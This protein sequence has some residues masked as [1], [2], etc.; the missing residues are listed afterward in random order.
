[1]K[2]SERETSGNVLRK[3]KLKLPIPV[4]AGET[5]CVDETGEFHNSEVLYPKYFVGT[6]HVN[7]ALQSTEQHAVK[8]GTIRAKLPCDGLNGALKLSNGNY[9]IFSLRIASSTPTFQLLA[10]VSS[11]ETGNTLGFGVSPSTNMHNNSDSTNAYRL[12]HAV[13]LNATNVRVLVAFQLNASNY[14]LKVFNVEIN[15]TTSA[16]TVTALATLPTTYTAWPGLTGYAGVVA[17]ISVS[18]QNFQSYVNMSTN[19]L[20]AMAN[21][22]SLMPTV[23]N[24]ATLDGTKLVSRYGSSTS[25]QVIDTASN[26]HISVVAS[27]ENIESIFQLGP[28]VYLLTTSANKMLVVTFNAGMNAIT[29]TQTF[30]LNTRLLAALGATSGSLN[31]QRALRVGQSKVYIW[32]THGLLLELALD[33]NF[34]ITSILSKADGPDKIYNLGLWAFNYATG[35]SLFSY[36]PDLETDVCLYM[37]N[38]PINPGTSPDYRSYSC[39]ALLEFK[40]WPYVG[41]YKP[42]C[43][44]VALESQSAEAEAEFLMFDTVLQDF[45]PLARGEYQAAY[46]GLGSNFCVKLSEANVEKFGV[47]QAA[48]TL[49]ASNFATSNAGILG[50][51]APKIFQAVDGNIAVTNLNASLPLYAYLFSPYCCGY[52]SIGSNLEQT[53][54]MKDFAICVV[55]PISISIQAC[56]VM[57]DL[58]SHN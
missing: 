12:L 2:A 52:A 45:A 26:T 21:A 14:A 32:S 18:N 7:A 37:I 24:T 31:I 55:A 51:H 19:T 58:K 57:Y 20:T 17:Y 39:M 15:A 34:Q 10:G 28:L 54:R 30:D 3:A 50:V 6:A 33:S 22:T 40:P 11:S 44:G 47:S 35:G 8:S 49:V 27:P 53:Y 29:A 5:Y 25:L 48:T 43:F 38:H 46:V 9:L 56:N 23:T 13:Q 1:M 4:V 36:I 42:A 16:V 41:N